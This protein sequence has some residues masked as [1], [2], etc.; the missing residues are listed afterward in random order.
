METAFDVLL[1]RGFIEQC[2]DEEGL[3]TLFQGKKVAFYIGFDP[4]AQSLHVGNLLGLMAMMHLKMQGQH[5]LAI[6]GGGTA[7]VGDPSGKNEMRDILTRATISCNKERL[8][9]QLKW[10]LKPQEGKATI[11]DNAEWLLEVGLIKFLRE[12]GSCFSVN[13]MLTVESYKIRLEKGLSFLEFSYQLLQAYDFWQVCQRYGCRVQMGGSDQWGNIVAGI[14]LVR[15]KEGIQAYG[16]VF[17][18]LTTR[19]GEKMGKTARG[20]VWLSDDILSPYEY[21]QYWMNV[22][23]RDVSRLLKLY[24]FLPLQEIEKLSLLKE[25]HIRLAKERLAYEATKIT[26][27][28]KAAETAQKTSR[29][30]FGQGEDY[31]KAPSATINIEEIRKGIPVSS[32]LVMTKLVKS[33]SEARRLIEQGGFYWEGERLKD[34]EFIID[35][36][37]LKGKSEF[38]LRCGRKKYCRV[39]VVEGNPEEMS[40]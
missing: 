13:R 5:P 29:A 37:F 7:M 17:P 2:T 40:Q 35:Y 32:F 3:R 26:H 28:Q 31:S 18:I 21:Y 10:Y 39:V 33:K 8:E 19:N 24:T 11:V 15:R 30:L 38:L 36:S 20:A 23:D 34:K 16:A 14:D 12:I 22:D 27:G 4:T 6:L 25:E 9:K 1:K